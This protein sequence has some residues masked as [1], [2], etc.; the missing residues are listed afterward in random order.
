M[1]LSAMHILTAVDPLPSKELPPKPVFRPKR[2]RRGK[3]KR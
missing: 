1:L 2:K 3:S